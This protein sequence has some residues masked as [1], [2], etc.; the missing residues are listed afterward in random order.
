MPRFNLYYTTLLSERD[1]DDVRR[2]SVL[3]PQVA[4]S[5]RHQGGEDALVLE[6][7]HEKGA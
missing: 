6:T 5:R 3:E 2:G 4:L 1:A 7:A